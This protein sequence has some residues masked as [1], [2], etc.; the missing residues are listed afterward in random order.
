M[1]LVSPKLIES[2]LSGNPLL[3]QAYTMLVNDPEVQALWSMA[4]VMAVNRLRYNDHG[5]VHAHI[6]A[7]ASLYIYQLLLS[8]GVQPSLLRD[9][10]VDDV[11]YTWLVPLLGSLLHDVG[12]SVHRDMHERIGAVIAMPILDRVLGKLIQDQSIRVKLRQEVMHAIYCTSY[13]VECLTYEAGCVKVGDGVDMAEG[14]ARVPYRLGGVSIHSVSALSIKSVEIL[15]SERVSVRINVNMTERAGIF[16]VDEILIPKIS[17]TPLRSHIE[18]YALIGD[19]VV[20]SY[21][22]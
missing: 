19:T 1:V 21:I 5:P 9:G 17:S 15:P 22:P 11:G 3:K 8:K 6:A 10:V 12:N 7:G 13:D 18:V 20:K 2:M 14:R 16:Q 4:N